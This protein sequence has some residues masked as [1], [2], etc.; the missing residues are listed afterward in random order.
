MEEPTDG[1][2]DRGDVGM[3]RE[4]TQAEDQVAQDL[5]LTRENAEAVIA[6]NRAQATLTTARAS[7]RTTVRRMLAWVVVVGT[8][9]TWVRWH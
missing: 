7:L 6:H 8:I 4:Q 5:R 1:Q 2:R 9:W 3:N